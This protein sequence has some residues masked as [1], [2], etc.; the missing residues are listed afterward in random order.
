MTGVGDAFETRQR[1]VERPAPEEPIDRATVES[2][3]LQAQVAVASPQTVVTN[4]ANTRTSRKAALSERWAATKAA[5]SA[6]SAEKREA[7]ERKALA[8]AAARR[9]T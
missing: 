4:S 3:A 9:R 2:E 7:R 5:R 8:K 6:A 1:V